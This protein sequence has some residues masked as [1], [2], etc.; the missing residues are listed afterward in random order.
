MPCHFIDLQ[1]I[2]AVHPEYTAA[3]NVFP[4]EMGA[5]ALGD[6]IWQMMQ[7]ECVAQ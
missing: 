2:W 3:G 6:A 7:D 4:N 1:M 5:M